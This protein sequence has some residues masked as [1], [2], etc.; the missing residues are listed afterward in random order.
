MWSY[1]FIV[2]NMQNAFG[3]FCSSS[4]VQMSET[5]K[6]FEMGTILFKTILNGIIFLCYHKYISVFG[7]VPSSK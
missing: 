7:R 6:A 4:F 2:Q 3:I 1:S 5:M